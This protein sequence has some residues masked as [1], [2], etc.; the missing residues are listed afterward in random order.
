[1]D[2][3][4]VLARWTHFLTVIVLFGLTTWP[5]V[6]RTTR[7]APPVLHAALAVL[8]L[9]TG[10][11]WLV[12]TAGSMTG[13]PPDRDTINLVLFQT[14]F[15]VLWLVRALIAGLL[16]ALAWRPP[17]RTT[18]A[19][20]MFL[21]VALLIS[22]AGTGH[23]AAAEGVQ[24]WGHVLFDALH[25]LATGF[26]LG[27]LSGFCLAFT[28]PSEWPEA[29]LALERFASAGLVGVVGTTVAGAANTWFILG[30]FPNPGRP[31]GQ[32]LLAKVALALAMVVLA[33]INRFLVLPRIRDRLARAVL[34]LETLLGVGVLLVVAVL[35]TL[36]PQA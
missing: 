34:G 23:A 16:F 2:V 35:G 9:V 14:T 30:G 21:A 18:R 20:T 13:G 36:N 4:L 11:A 17:G 27:A 6:A 19:A 5:L 12:A 25:L 15:G 3:G 31:Y 29:R 33:S 32:W 7:P 24:L 8:A 1:M 10:A 26:W 28:R 22:L